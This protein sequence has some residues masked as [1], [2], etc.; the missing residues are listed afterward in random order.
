MGRPESTRSGRHS[1]PL[2]ISGLQRRERA[3]AENRADAARRSLK[4]AL[5]GPL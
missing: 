2:C 5:S 1:L 3:E 4:P